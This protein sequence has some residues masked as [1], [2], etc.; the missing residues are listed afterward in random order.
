MEGEIV[1]SHPGTPDGRWQCAYEFTATGFDQAERRYQWI[2]LGL[3][4]GAIF[5]ADG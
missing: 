3:Q 2:L 1:T 5:D 4:S